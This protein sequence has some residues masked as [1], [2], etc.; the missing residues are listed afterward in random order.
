MVIARS[1]RA[2]ELTLTI[3]KRSLTSMVP[4]AQDIFG[5]AAALQR[6]G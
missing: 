1:A 4:P 6:L 2:A 5:V 3:S